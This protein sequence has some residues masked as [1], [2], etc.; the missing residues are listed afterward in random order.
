MPSGPPSPHP[1]RRGALYAILLLFPLALLVLLRG[2][3]PFWIRH[4][5]NHAPASGSAYHWHV[6]NVDLHLFRGGYDLE[7]VTLLK[8][9]A[10]IPVF[11]AGKMSSSIRFKTLFRGPVTADA[12]AFRPRLNLYLEPDNRG[13][14]MRGSK[15]PFDGGKLLHRLTLFRLSG[16]TIHQ[17]EVHIHD[18]SGKTEVELT[19]K[20]VDIEAENLF[21]G[22]EDSSRW[23]GLKAEGRFMGSGRFTLETRVRPESESPDFDFRFT[24]RHM[25]LKDMDRALK[26][27]TG[28]AVEKGRLDLDAVAK[29]SGGKYRGTVHSKLHDFALEPAPEKEK[30]WVKAVREKAARIAG[31][32]LEWKTEKNEAEGKAPP[33]FDFSGD[34]PPEVHN[35]WSMSGYLLKEA[36]RKGLKP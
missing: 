1:R 10:P 3:A 5:I 16:F 27:Y 22:G 2:A 12:E 28:M 30:G 11:Q 8:E 17:G 21:R 6:E 31:G 32:I 29:A 20:E 25:D 4:R 9:G 26:A 24:L 18:L 23:A 34:F 7:D 33:K 19:A 13:S 14:G 36:F 35:A 15:K